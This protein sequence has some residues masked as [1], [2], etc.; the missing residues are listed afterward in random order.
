VRKNH[1]NPRSYASR[2]IFERKGGFFSAD[3]YPIL[4]SEETLCRPL[5]NCSFEVNFLVKGGDQPSF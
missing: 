2:S 5:K 4:C 3:L 1:R